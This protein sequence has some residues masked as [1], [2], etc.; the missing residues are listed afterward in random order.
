MEVTASQGTL[1]VSPAVNP[2]NDQEGPS[3]APVATAPSGVVGGSGVQSYDLVIDCNEQNEEVT[4]SGGQGLDPATQTYTCASDQSET[5]SLNL[6]ANIE[7]PDPNNFTLSSEDEYGNPANAT[8][9]VNIPIDTQ[10]PRVS[11]TN[12]GNIT[13]GVTASFIITVTDVNFENA[14]YTPTINQA[15]AT[16]NP[17]ACTTNPCSLTVSGATSGTLTLTVAANSVTDSVSN[18]GPSSLV[19]S[20]LSVGG[21]SLSVD[22]LDMVTSA[23]AA[24][25][26]VSGNCENSQG[27]VTVTAGTPNAS[28]SSACSGQRYTVTLDVSGVNSNPMTVS[29]SQGTNTIAPGVHPA[30]D[31]NGPASAPTATAPSGAVGGASYSL[32]IDCNEAHEEVS[33]TGGQGLNPVTQNYTCTS[34]G[35]KTWSLTLASN[36]ETTS[37]NILTLSSE[38][39]HGNPAGSTTTVNVPI[40]TRSP[41]VV[42]THGGNITEG[43]N[44]TFT[45]TVTDGNLQSVNYAPTL[46]QNSATLHPTS[47]TANP[48]TLTVSGATQGSLTLTVAAN[49]V[50]D[51]VSNTGPSSLVSSTLSVGG[52]SLSVDSLDMVTSANAASYMVSGNCENS[53]GSVTVTAGTPN[54]SASS[55]CSGQRYTVTLDVSGVN[56]NPMTVSISQGTNTIAPGTQPANDQNGPASAPTATA[57]SGAVGGASYGLAI[58]CNEAHEEVSITGGQGLNPTTQNYTCTSSGSKTWSLT[59][60]SNVETTSSNI[61]TL[62]SEDEHGNPAGS[63]TTVNVPIDTRSPRVVVTHGGNITEGSNATFTISVTDANLGSVSYTPTINQN[64]ATLSPTSCAVN[65]C[66]ITVSG[67]TETVGTGQD[68]TLT[69]AANSITDSISNTGPSSG[70]SKSLIV[71]EAPTTTSLLC[72]YFDGDGSGRITYYYDNESNDST[73]PACPRDI[74]MPN[75]IT[76]IGS[77]ALLSTAITSVELPDSLITIEANAFNQNFLESIVI[78]DS[79]ISIGNDAFA[80][81]DLTSIAISN[82]VTSI[83]SHT[84]A[85]NSLISIVIPTSVTSIG[86]GAFDGNDATLNEVCIESASTD[87]TLGANA[88][89][90]VTPTYESDEDCSN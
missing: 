42:V 26:M 77:A 52:S 41:R 19:S 51:S 47:C 12:G 20:T 38:D 5:W 85:N 69:V 78:P 40:D 61:L 21:S 81:N 15:S 32:A 70:V 87:I 28:A 18:T 2:E 24:S 17:T 29:I 11:I 34:S 64:S 82:S 1:E 79:V 27:S 44:A 62:S 76:S 48:C 4:I 22:S 67:A 54:A 80:N 23:N 14:S 89:G 71:Y 88:F 63:T 25:Y 35:S 49:S 53:Q 16:L 13:A 55:T 46:N 3:M 90:D 45:V 9:M 73:N 65:P 50:T 84:F 66:T 33:I 60:A 31:Q 83:G 74:I 59:L 39:E 36:V 8:V 37:S 72:F 68:L 30:N 43:S 58:D 56:S 6:A 75:T 86:A 57:P 10:G 7:T